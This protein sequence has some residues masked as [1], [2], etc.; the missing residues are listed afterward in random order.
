MPYAVRV[1]CISRC[2]NCAGKFSMMPTAVYYSDKKAYCSKRQTTECPT[3]KKTLTISF[4]ISMEEFPKYDAC[5][6]PYLD[7]TPSVVVSSE[8][9]SWAFNDPE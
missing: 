1:H 2:P 9:Q 3:C 7:A 4:E 6:T 8:R 5:K